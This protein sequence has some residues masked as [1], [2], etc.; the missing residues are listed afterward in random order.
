MMTPRRRD[1]NRK[2]PPDDVYPR[3]LAAIR[4][5]EITAPPRLVRLLEAAQ[6]V[7]RSE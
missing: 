7:S 4:R 1:V 2:S 6:V 3:L 5:G